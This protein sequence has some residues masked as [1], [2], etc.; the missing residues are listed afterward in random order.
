MCNRCDRYP[1][2]EVYVPNLS[3][4]Q[5]YE[6]SAPVVLGRR[7]RISSTRVG[8]CFSR[9]SLFQIHVS[10]ESTSAT[11]RSFTSRVVGPIAAFGVDTDSHGSCHSFVE[12]SFL[13]TMPKCWMRTSLP[14]SIP[15]QPCEARSYMILS[16]RRLCGNTFLAKSWLADS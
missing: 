14:S 5:E 8:N 4:S 7:S 2:F 15:L 13:I 12:L 11:T 10:L 1:D 9:A 16:G 6:S 3:S